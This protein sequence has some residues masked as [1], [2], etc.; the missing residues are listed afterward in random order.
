LT[1]RWRIFRRFAIK[2]RRASSCF[3]LARCGSS[4][5]ALRRH[6]AGYSSFGCNGFA[7]GSGPVSPPYVPQARRTCLTSSLGPQRNRAREFIRMRGGP[8]GQE[9]RVVMLAVQ[10]LSRL[11]QRRAATSPGTAPIVDHPS[12]VR[13][14]RCPAR[15]QLA[16]PRQS[17]F[18]Q[19]RHGPVPLWQSN[20]ACHLA[21]R[22][23]PDA[24]EISTS[25]PAQP[26]SRTIKQIDLPA[27]VSGRQNVQ[28]PG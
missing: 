7:V 4:C 14:S 16:P 11:G 21:L 5:P 3:F 24:P 25:T 15:I 23:A 13:Q 8:L 27:P 17:A 9:P 12:C 20:H 6:G 10:L 19:Y 2:R 22:R 18:F 1:H 26:K 28:N